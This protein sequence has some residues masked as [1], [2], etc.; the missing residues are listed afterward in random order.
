MEKVAQV[1]PPRPSHLLRQVDPT[2]KSPVMPKNAS[3]AM[4][5]A[6]ELNRVRFEPARRKLQQGSSD[7]SSLGDDS[8]PESLEEEQVSGGEDE[9]FEVGRWLVHRGGFVRE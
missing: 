9:E 4:T 2:N 8:D 5:S 3:T 7:T 1:S 6:A